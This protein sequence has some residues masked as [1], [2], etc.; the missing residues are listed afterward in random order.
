MKTQEI[1]TPNVA[2]CTPETPLHEAAR[3]MRDHDCGA[4]PVLE[5]ENPGE[6]TGIVTD[7]DLAVR[8]LARGYDSETAVHEVMT[9]NP[10]CCSPDD[11]VDDVERLM[12]QHQ[13][14]RVPVV[15]ENRHVRGM[16][17]QADLARSN[18]PSVRKDVDD[19]VEAISEP[20][21]GASA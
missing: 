12:S 11:E 7:R 15:D 18:D 21:E 1:M 14:R 5:S 13:I 17:A 9:A 20:A 2:C 4:L 3:L 16:V 6:V 8:G 10:Y 19:V